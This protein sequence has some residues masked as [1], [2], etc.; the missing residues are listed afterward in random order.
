MIVGTKKLLELVKKDRLVEGLS[1]REL[2]NPEGAGFDLRLGEVFELSGKG[3]LGIDERQTPNAKSVA[4]F[5]PKKRT[6]FVFRPHK[7]YLVKTIE[8]VTVPE[9]M[10]GLFRTRG[11]LFRSGA[12]IYTGVADPGYSG[13]LNFAMINH[14]DLDFEVELG[15]RIVFVMFYKVEGGVISKYR[16]QW[17][18]GRTDAR[19]KEKQV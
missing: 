17:Q 10:V 2:T 11:T 7:F 4:R 6:S 13:E 19:K 3:F 15:A 14:S 16:G 9:N 8:K 5:E 18:G 12:A 1:E